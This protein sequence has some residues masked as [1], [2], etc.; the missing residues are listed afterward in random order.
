MADGIAEAYYGLSAEPK[1]KVLSYL[2]PDMK[3]LRYAFEL[4]YKSGLTGLE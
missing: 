4:I 1:K 3:G 2:D